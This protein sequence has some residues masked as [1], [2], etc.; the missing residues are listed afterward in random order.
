MR[1][2]L[3]LSSGA[4]GRQRATA[5][6]AAYRLSVDICSGRRHVVIRDRRTN[7]TII[8]G[9]YNYYTL[10]NNNNNYYCRRRRRRCCCR[11]YTPS[12]IAGI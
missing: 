7:T 4:G 8:R 9:Y 5:A 12:V 6:G 3:L 2:G 11:Y 1:H 10:Y